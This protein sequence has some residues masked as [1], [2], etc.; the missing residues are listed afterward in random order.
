WPLL[1]LAAAASMAGAGEASGGAPL[2]LKWPNDVT[3]RG[4]KLCG[5]LAESRAVGGGGLALVIGVGVNVNQREEDLPPEL[6]GRATSLRI[7]S[8]GRTLDRE[9]LLSEILRRFGEAVALSR[10]G[11]PEPLF[12]SLRPHLPA[13]GRPVAV[14][15]GD[16]LIEGPVESV[17]PTGALRVRDVRSGL[18]ETVAA[19]ELA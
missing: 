15:L 18:V 19:G 9:A 4:R 16:R 2:E 11:G 5:V 13:P 12:E 6:R 7:A 3:H 10:V 8:G 17:L 1:A 14:R